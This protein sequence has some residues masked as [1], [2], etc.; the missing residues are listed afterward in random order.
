MAIEIVDF[1]MKHGGSFH[2]FLLTF[3]SILWEVFHGI[4]LVVL[5]CSDWGMALHF[6]RQWLSGFKVPMEMYL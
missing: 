5:K 2:S 1:P 6:I 3:T 4:H